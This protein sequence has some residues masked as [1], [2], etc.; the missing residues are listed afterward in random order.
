VRPVPPETAASAEPEPAAED[1]IAKV[2]PTRPFT[3]P[4]ARGDASKQAASP[5][6]PMPDVALR[7]GV[8]ASLP[9]ALATRPTAPP[10]PELRPPLP[11]RADVAFIPAE[12]ITKVLPQY[13]QSAVK[14]GAPPISLE[15]EASVDQYGKVVKTRVVSISAPN[16]VLVGAA[17]SAVSHWRFRPASRGGV[18]VPSSVT[19]PFKFTPRQ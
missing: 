15:V 7:A 12:A 2:T 6:E 17:V 13:P 5:L 11:K 14:A 19:I 4:S 16:P 1:I 10:A 9:A 18:P 3:A 8:P